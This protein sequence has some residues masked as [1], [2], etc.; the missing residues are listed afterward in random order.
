MIRW[1][2]EFLGTAPW[3]MS[4]QAGTD[5]IVDVRLL[6]D[7][8]GNSPEL[9][10][11]KVAEAAGHLSAGRRV[12]LCCDHGISRSNAM[13]AAVLAGHKGIPYSE[14]LRCVIRATGETGIKID[15]AADLRE[16][17]QDGQDTASG[18]AMFVLGADGVIGCAVRSAFGNPG[19]PTRAED[20]QALINTPVLLEATLSEAAAGMVLL[21][22]HP[23]RLDTNL[24]AGQLVTGLR[25]VLE[26]CRVRKAGL[27][28]LSGQ[29]VFSGLKGD[30]PVKCAENDE[31]SPEGAAGDGLYL[32]EDLIRQY[33]ARHG[34]AALI[35]RPSHIYGV[36]DE[37]P[38]F[39]A[40]FIRKALAGE[41]IET[42]VFQ[43]SAP[44]VDLLHASDLAQ[45]VMRAVGLGLT[46]VLH[47]ASGT[48]I[49]TDA[50]ARMIIQT[51]GS[52]SGVSAVE[53]PGRCSQAQLD[54]S[55]ARE[56]LAWRPAVGLQ[57]G[58]S[59]LIRH[60]ASHTFEKDKHDKAQ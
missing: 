44:R 43:N 35:V 3:E 21:F 18:K 5:G 1:I 8:A 26:V 13:A 30:G 27:V 16:I 46:G 20:V 41:T 34:L 14:A 56:T 19:G 29:Q 10:R 58:L 45:A 39:L 49:A 12:V 17:M 9:V 6:R 38:G 15:L 48:P 60:S 11:R 54:A 22:W 2:T 37:R 47:V 52:T 59:E 53:M 7:G 23:P 36:G 4:P 33:V 42:H 50:L 32:A 25:N 57:E 31:P 55:L 40:N 28:F 51:A 24:A